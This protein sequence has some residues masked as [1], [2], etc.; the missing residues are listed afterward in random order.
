MI[1]VLIVNYFSHALTVRAVSSVLAEDAAAQVIVVDNSHD[2]S[3]ADNLRGALT[4]RA[5]LV[6]AT[7]NLGFGRACNLALEQATG[8]WILLLN[9][10]AYLLPGC[11]QQL[12]HTLRQDARIGAV[13]PVAQ[14]DEAGYFLLP[15][16]QMQTPAWECLLAIGHSFP[17]LGAWL[18]KRFKS[19]SMKCLYARRPVRQSMLSG[20]HML[21]RRS[22]IDVVGGLFDPAFFMYYEDVDLCRRLEL[23]GFKLMLDPAARVVHQWRNDPVKLEH[24]A[25]ARALYMDKHFSAVSL[26][27]RLQ[28]KFEHRTPPKTAR[29]LDFG[30]C[31][32]SPA[33]HLPQH[34]VGNW[35]LELS[36]DPLF[37]PAAL[38][39]GPVAPDHIPRPV[40]D[41]L[42]PARYWARVTHPGG[43]GSLFTWLI[44]EPE[45]P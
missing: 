31:T 16:G 45:S 35:M 10:D 21:L 29:F 34:E 25:R 8:D 28:R 32:E 5:K 7:Q 18:S 4:V 40:W 27:A 20:G 19:F 44:P 26:A 37:I 3:E 33:F 12:Q 15:P 17:P 42:G 6:I 24:A 14:W 9:P 30:I 38:H 13:S 43:Q 41:L 11:L 39:R 22:A 2:S 23:A 36:P 1:S